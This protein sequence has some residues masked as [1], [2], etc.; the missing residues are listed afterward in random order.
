MGAAYS[1]VFGATATPH[2]VETLVS[3]PGK[4]LVAGGYLVL[5]RAYTGLVVATSSR[6]Y[7]AVRDEDAATATAPWSARITVRAG[8]FPED[9]STWAYD[10]SAM[11]QD[12][13]ARVKLS[14]PQPNANKNKFVEITLLNVLQYA[15]ER[16]GPFALVEKIGQGVE[17]V[18][19]ADNDFYSQRQQVGPK[20]RGPDDLC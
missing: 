20:C 18:V 19:L 7:C 6:F 9:A 2:P 13:I 1:V 17:V 16:V 8:Q 14:Q 4:V 11:M 5:D 15:A 3:A 10:V 12:G